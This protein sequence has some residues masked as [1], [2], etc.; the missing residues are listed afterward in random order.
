LI[1]S[2]QTILLK[3][4]LSPME[5]RQKVHGMTFGLGPAGYDI[6]VA[7]YVH[8]PPGAFR[9]ASS[10]ERFHMPNDLLGV[11]HD[12]STWAR[13]GVTVQN[14]VIEPGWKGYLTLELCN[15]GREDVEIL[16]GSPIAQVIFHLLD[17]PTKRPYKGKY[18]NQAPGPQSA[19]LEG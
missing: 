2:W 5:D 6:R 15:H 12:K 17:Q 9:L 10:V 3:Q 1:A 13:L 18:Q 4:P 8:L 14:T 19:I 16:M 11:V 7:E